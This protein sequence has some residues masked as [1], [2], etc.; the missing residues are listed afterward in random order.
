MKSLGSQFTYLGILKAS[1]EVIVYIKIDQFVSFFFSGC[2][3]LWVGA[4]AQMEIFAR[5]LLLIIMV[6]LTSSIGKMAAE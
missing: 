5:S 6:A 1:V 4:F 2:R 3:R